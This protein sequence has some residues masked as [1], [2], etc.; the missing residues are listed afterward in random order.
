MQKRQKRRIPVSILQILHSYWGSLRAHPIAIVLIGVGVVGIQ[1]C[2]ILVSLRFSQFFNALAADTLHDSAAASTLLTILYSVAALFV[3]QW[4]MRRTFSFAL[5]YVELRVEREL[6]AR[7]FAHIIRHSSEFFSNQF[8]GTLTRRISKYV[9]AFEMLFDSLTMTFAPAFLYITGAVVVLWMHNRMLGLLLGGWAIVFVTFQVL[10]SLW[11]QPLRIARSEADSAVVG[12]VADA[13]GNQSAILHFARAAYESAR[14]IK[15]VDV[16]QKATK[17]AWYADEYIWSAQGV[18]MIGVQLGLF[19]TALHYWLLGQASI[20]DFVLIQTY[21]WGVIENLLNV[22]RELRRVYDAFA[23]ASEAV[24]L[25]ALP[26]GIRDIEHAKPIHVGSG[27]IVFENVHFEYGESSSG[28]LSQ[29]SLGIPSQQKVGLI[30]RSGAG[31]STLV[32]LILRHY[33]VKQGVITIDGQSIAEVTQDSL[34]ESIGYVPQEPILFHRTLRENIAYGKLDATQEEIER[35]AAMAHAHEFIQKLPHGYDT[36]V[37]E[38]GVKLS[39][40]ERQRIAIARAILKNAPI[41]LL[42]EATSALDSESE[43]AIQAA[44]H[45]LMKGKTV[46]A[47]AH[48]LSTLR[49]MDRIIVMDEGKIVED[50]SHTELLKKRGVYA[51]LWNHQAGGFIKE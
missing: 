1:A 30:G 13:I 26:H 10:I 48:R 36:M 12:G 46:I 14:F 23:D 40:G 22:T 34:H 45:E 19:F 51:K 27:T 2:S 5:M 35:A 38:R 33:N 9:K 21:A 3:L 32:K 16:W 24:E 49:E 43:V 41:L 42:D 6:F 50:G 17:R 39:G 44:L 37:G 11:R 31:K 4:V 47:I 25:L 29:F 20:G 18:L 28:V 15:L 8:A 7:A